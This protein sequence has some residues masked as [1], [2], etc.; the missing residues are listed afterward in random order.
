M[1]NLYWVGTRQSD[2][3]DTGCVF[4]GSVTIFGDNKGGNISYCSNG[5]R[6]NHN[7]EDKECDSFFINTLETI[8]ESDTEA[9]FMFYDPILAYKYGEKIKNHTICLNSYDL[10]NSF[11]N[12]YKARYILSN[13]IN[14]VPY[15]LLKGSKCDCSTLCQLFTNYNEFVIQKPYSSGGDA[16]YHLRSTSMPEVTADELYLVSPFFKDALSVNIHLV[17]SDSGVLLFP[18]SVQIINETKN[19]LL[20]SGADFI[21][22]NMI[23][24]EIKEKVNNESIKIGNILMRAGYRGVIGIDYI[25]KDNTP[26]FLELNTRFQASSHLIN[27]SLYP[28]LGTFLQELNIKAFRGNLTTDLHAFD[29]NYSMFIYTTSNIQKSRLK[30][31][32]LSN[33]IHEAQTDGY[34]IS[35][36]TIAGENIYLSRIVFAKNICSINNGT[37]ILHPNIVC[38]NLATFLSP[39]NPYFKENTKISLLNHG[40]IFTNTA[41]DFCRKRGDIK[42]AVF[43]AIDAVIFNKVYVNIPY[44]CKFTSFTPFSIDVR[45]NQLILLY[46]DNVISNID[47]FYT[48]NSLK[49]KFTKSGVPFESIINLATDRIRVNP[50]PVCI[51]KQKGV[52]CKFCNLPKYNHSY[53]LEDCKEVISYCLDNIKFRHFLI[54][55]GTIGTGPKSW[56]LIIEI[57]SFIRSQSDKDI[58]LMSIPPYDLKVLDQLKTAGITEVAFNLEM[59]NR[60]LA[61]KYMP[62]KGAISIDNYIEALKYAVS[63]WGRSGRVRSLLIYGFDTDQAFAD[64]IEKLCVLGIEPIIS[65]FRPLNGTEFEKLNPPPTE[66]LLSIYKKC[67]DIT[68]KYGLILGP[69]CPMCQNNTLSFTE[70]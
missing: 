35:A 33:E 56:D 32:M 43:D 20:Y 2:I 55:G 59:F 45:N 37:S 50:A 7:I 69:D 11:S 23:C 53:T 58:Y 48:P 16:T 36:P 31:I 34:D 40:I 44:K 41:L 47:I 39:K 42:E 21:C 3:F 29:V 62:G 25:I 30:R 64:G 12:K 8:L 68:K 5:K 10:L 17:I 70:V 1:G 61:N 67:S 65:V 15:A 22:Y 63:L 14:T 6:I 9:R 18:A 19:R 4:K 49:N 26:Y 27:K 46:N 54:G 38:D 57:A 60:D 52:A 13:V 66:N 28:L 51:Y 24:E